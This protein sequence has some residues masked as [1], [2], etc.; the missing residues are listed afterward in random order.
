MEEAVCTCDLYE[1][2]YYLI[3]GCEITESVIGIRS[4]I[5]RD[6]RLARTVMMGA[7]GYEGD[8]PRQPGDPPLG[9]GRDCQIEGA[10]IGNRTQKAGVYHSQRF[11]S[12]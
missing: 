2:A 8:L 10:I 7:D 1:G 12:I 5:S 4:V 9:I 6:A 11:N 3:H